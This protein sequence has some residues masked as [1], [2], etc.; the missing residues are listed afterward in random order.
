MSAWVFGHS[1]RVDVAATGPPEVVFPIAHIPLATLNMLGQLSRRAGCSVL[2]CLKLFED[3]SEYLI[4][5][6]CRLSPYRPHLI[7]AFEESLRS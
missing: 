1:R 4:D 6:L 5:P 2:H 3:P 7:A